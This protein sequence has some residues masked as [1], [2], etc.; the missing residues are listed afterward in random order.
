VCQTDSD[1]ILSSETERIKDMGLQEPYRGP[2]GF[3]LT[4]GY[5]AA[6]NLLSYRVTYMIP[7][8]F[9]KHSKKVFLKKSKSVDV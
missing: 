1:W 6:R 2:A 4:L 3:R 9:L 8:V 7:K 5:W